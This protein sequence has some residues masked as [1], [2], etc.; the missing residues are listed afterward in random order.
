VYEWR[1]DVSQGRRGI[2]LTVMVLV[3]SV[4]G[5][6]SARHSRDTRP[7]RDPA[8]SANL[9]SSP[10]SSP[11]P[12]PCGDSR[13]AAL[14]AFN[15]DGSPRWSIDL[16]TGNDEETQ[17]APIADQNVIFTGHAG[18][19]SALRVADGSVEWDAQLGG[20][21]YSLWLIDGL[22]V[23]NVDQVS[24]QAKIVG[25]DP[26]TGA[27]RWTYTVPG[28]GF[29]GD[30]VV[31]GDG[32][33]AFRIGDTGTLTVIDVSSGQVR[34]SRHVGG[35]RSPNDL[36]SAGSG[37]V[38]Y[39]DADRRLLALDARTGSVRWQVSGAEPSGRVVVSGNDAVVVPDVVSGP[40]ITVVAHSL[41]DGAEIW[42][43]KL[44][45]I[46]AVFPDRS[47]FLLVDYRSNTMTLVQATRGTQLWHAQ[48]RSIELDQAPMTLHPEDAIAVLER[49]AVAF[50][51]RDS[52]NVRQ[53]S[54]PAGG[55]YAAASDNGLFLAS[56]T[57]VLLVTPT[58]VSWT[59]QVA[60]Y[61]HTRPAVLDDGGVAVQSEDPICATAN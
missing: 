1:G 60:H 22:L 44:A 46:A 45:D 52:G 41:V 8:S 12:N 34:W 11:S 31:T 37:L 43:R 53:V 28:S 3:L 2:A 27:R 9:S 49:D 16:P 6:A 25:L 57:R 24:H 59:T 10:S 36:P 13:K 32:G 51:D 20:S 29:L 48:L 58:G 39:V 42:R 26:A 61:T 50:V 19:L 14:S 17:A 5:C 15:R 54:A 35:G 56:Q 33:L 40:T 23:A 47:G 4:T 21:V 7:R 38:F 55:G 30:A 18:S